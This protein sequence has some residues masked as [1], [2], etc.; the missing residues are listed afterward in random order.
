MAEMDKNIPC[1][2]KDWPEPIKLPGCIPLKGEALL[3]PLQ[4]KKK[5]SYKLTRT[6]AALLTEEPKVALR[7]KQSED[8][9]LGRYEIANVVKSLMACKILFLSLLQFGQARYLF[10]TNP[11]EKVWNYGF[12]NYILDFLYQS[13]L[14][15]RQPT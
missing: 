11:T 15:E 7:P 9:V 13:M 5:D 8:G 4:D 14:Q 2:F 1:E 10:Q 3:D 12:F 6:N